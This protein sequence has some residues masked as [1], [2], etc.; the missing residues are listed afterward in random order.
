MVVCGPTILNP[1]NAAWL[2]DPD[3]ATFLFGWRYFRA[4]PWSWPPGLNPDY[5]LGVSSSIVY[6]DSIPLFALPLNIVRSLWDIPQFA[7]IWLLACFVLQALFG[8]L[9]VGLA[10]TDRSFRPL[11]LIRTFLSAMRLFRCLTF[12]CRLPC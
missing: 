11:R 5:G 7:G 12:L 9:L 6:S 2:T 1:E 10:S 8:W 3:P 4:A